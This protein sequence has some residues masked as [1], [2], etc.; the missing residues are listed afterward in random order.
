LICFTRSAVALRVRIALLHAIA[1]DEGEGSIPTNAEPLLKLRGLRVFVAGHKGMVGSAIIRRLGSEDCELLVVDRRDVDLTNQLATETY[2]SDRRPDVVMVAAA[3]VGGILANSTLPAEFLSQNLAIAQNVIGAAHRSGVRKLL[4]L[5]SS[6]I[7]PRHAPQPMNEQSLLAGP[8]EPTNEW[9]AIAKIAGI[10]LCQAYRRQYGA[11]FISLMPA[12]LYGPG[13][14]YHPEH[15]HVPAALIRRM[16]EAK[17]AGAAS[18]TVW[19]TGSPMREFLYVEDLADACIFAIKHYSDEGF[20]NVG[21]G[22][23]ISIADFARLVGDVVGYG[24]TM[25]FDSS[26]PDGMPRKLLDVSKLSALGWRARTGLRSGLET[27]YADF[28]ANAGHF[29]GSTSGGISGAR[30]AAAH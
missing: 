30:A 16:H 2:M 26:K 25:L 17:L 19:G 9:Y 20:L 5:G 4:F 12:N 29:R 1:V 24:G 11:D 6:C 27:T 3:R 10:K 23:E 21:T 22:K 15:S 13:D 7:Y 28:V 18:V 8:F 14:N